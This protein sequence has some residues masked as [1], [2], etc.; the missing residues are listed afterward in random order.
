MEAI[1]DVIEDGF[2][3]SLEDL[4]LGAGQI[5]DVIV[6]EGDFALGVFDGQ[7]RALVDAVQ[8]GWG[9]CQFRRVEWPKPAEDLDVALALHLYSINT[10]LS[11]H[12][13]P[14]SYYPLALA[15]KSI[16]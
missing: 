8:D 6:E 3:H 15:I 14:S 5:E 7:L 13:S 12:P 2:S 10:A 11:N 4:L 1:K 9:S 16:S